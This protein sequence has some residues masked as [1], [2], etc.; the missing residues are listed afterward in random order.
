MTFTNN[1]LRANAPMVSAGTITNEISVAHNTQI[2]VWG[3]GVTAGA[4]AFG[5]I[6]SYIIISNPNASA[7]Q[8]STT[9]TVNGIVIP[10]GAS[11]E[12][13]LDKEGAIYLFQNSG[14]PV[15]VTGMMFS[16]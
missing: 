16:P 13:A 2:K 6:G 12:V 11:F 5:H 4:A 10:A 7:V 9:S 1:A 15:D 14:V 3:S 8:V